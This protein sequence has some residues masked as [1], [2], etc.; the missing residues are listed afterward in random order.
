MYYSYKLSKYN[1]ISHCFLSRKGG[2]SKGIYKSLNCGKG[3]LDN[4][5]NVNKFSQQNKRRLC[6]T[7]TVKNGIIH[8]DYIEKDGKKQSRK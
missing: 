1:S 8:E 5:F 2:N 7:L 4:K 3:S 6:G